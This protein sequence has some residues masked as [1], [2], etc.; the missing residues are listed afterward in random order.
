M[1]I[2]LNGKIVDELSLIVHNQNMRT[3]ARNVCLKLTEII[4]RQ[5]FLVTYKSL[6]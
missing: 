1:D 3:V 5:Q 4:D 2:L 6:H